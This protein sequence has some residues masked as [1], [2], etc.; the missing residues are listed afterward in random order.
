MQRERLARRSAVAVKI[1][2]E[3]I[4]RRTRLLR[5]L[6][7]A[8][9]DRPPVICIG[10]SMIAAPEEVVLASGFNLPSAH[11]D[12]RAMAGLA[13]AA[14]RITGF[15]SVG[16]P[17]CTTIEAE[18]FGASIDLGNARTEA[19]IVHEP[20]NTVANLQLP[21][22]DELLS[23]GRVGLTV[24]AVRELVA[25]GSDL[26]VFA[27]VIG[28]A[29]IAAGV[30]APTTFLRELRTKTEQANALLTRATD[31]LI[32][33]TRQLIEAGADVIA[34]NED[35]ATPALIGPR[36]FDTFIA[37][38]LHRLVEAI[39]GSGGKAVLHMCGALGKAAPTVRELNLDGYLPDASLSPAEVREALPGHI[40][41]GNISTF[42]LHQGEPGE[43][44]RLADRLVRAGGVD[45][46]SPTCGMSS[47]TPL[48]NILAM[49]GAARCVSHNLEEATHDG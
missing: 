13:L 43:I 36:S 34:I 6:S 22:V 19:R 30:V 46:L 9:V 37:P 44:A 12:P 39:H 8:S 24:E 15:E 28:P 2:R 31:F 42:L 29:S 41:I 16:V 47:V 4:D 10:G 17:L 49:T 48:A 38:H 27:N 23:R 5:V 20:F 3:D 32:A 40:V 26:P 35:T 1:I 25:A 21:S 45:V 18:A 14:A 11:T 33:W 7:G